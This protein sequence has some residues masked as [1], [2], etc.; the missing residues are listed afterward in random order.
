MYAPPPLIRQALDPGRSVVVEACA[1][2]GKTWLLASRIVRLLLAGIA[3]GEIL[4]I[5]FTRKAAREI[6]DRVVNWL[7]LL[8]TGS[9]A[10]V[11]EFL[12]ERG[13]TPDESALRVARGLYERVLT[14]Q[15]RLAVNTFHGWFLQLVDAAPLSANLAGATL[16]DT[17]ARLFDETW[18]SFAAEL[19]KAPE[20]DLTRCFIGLL[21]E[22]GLD[23]S[24]R[25]IRRA[26]DRRSEW[27]AFG[28][29]GPVIVENVIAA[30]REQL[31]A[32]EPGDALA[33][34][35]DDGWELDFQAY[36]GFLEMSELKSDQDAAASLR[37]VLAES[38]RAVSF[39]TL[40]SVLLTKENTLR[41]KRP[42]NALDKRFTPQGAMR[43]LDLHG[44]LG[45]RVLACV[46][47]QTAERILAFNRQ[48]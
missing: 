20:S 47:A 40:R 48:A 6:E 23:S 27:L 11:A 4:A 7:H 10:Q 29:N 35:F 15:P 46:E 24:R 13:L 32:G 21:G 28:E 44:Q 43:F 17:D 42:G 25:L 26:L 8:A 1:G 34:F 12:A 33:A 9:T 22:A 16:V 18:Q 19:A 31:G 14:A 45:E 39:E 30:L 38:D 37:A 41:A 36:L 5:T 3:P 2:S